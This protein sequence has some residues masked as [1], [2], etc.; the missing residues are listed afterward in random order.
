[1]VAYYNNA[2]EVELYLNGESQG[3]KKKEGEMMHVMWRLKYVPGELKAI[4]RKNGEVVKE[5]IIKT[6]GEPAKIEL[7]ADRTT[8]N[9]D[10]KDLSF[11]TVRVLDK[12]GNL[13][14]RADNKIN[15]K[16]EGSGFIAGVDNGYQASHEPFKANYRKAYNGMC[17]AI[18]QSNG[19]KG[20]IELKA[21]AEGLESDEI[22]INAK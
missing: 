18:I 9:A 13:V 21:K 4:S 1:M 12:D 8:I 15:F 5:Q 19:T 14:P 2:D 16:V 3:V 11:V 20:N 22:V 10:G 17:L 6:A 7:I